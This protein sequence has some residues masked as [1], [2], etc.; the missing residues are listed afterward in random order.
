M[1]ENNIIINN[2]EIIEKNTNKNQSILVI[3]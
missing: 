3:E 2:S 1:S